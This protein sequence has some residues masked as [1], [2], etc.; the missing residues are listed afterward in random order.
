MKVVRVFG[1]ALVLLLPWSLAA[2]PIKV[3]TYDLDVEFFP[4]RHFMSASATIHFRDTSV[5]PDTLAF[6]LHGELRVDSLS[7]GKRALAAHQSSEF[8]YYDYSLIARR[9]ELDVSGCSLGEGLTVWYSGY[10]HPSRA[11]APSDY[12][13]IDGD[14]VF[15]RSYGYSVW[16]PV[17]LEQS[18]DSYAVSFSRARIR[19][20]AEFVSVFVGDRTAA[21]S[22]AGTRIT[23]WRVEDVDLADVQCT[24]RRFSVESE[25]DFHVYYLAE[26]ESRDRAR[27]I[28]EFTR[29]LTGF[30]RAHYRETAV[31]GELHIMQM[32]QY[33]DISC[34]NVA[35]IS[36]DA[37]MSF[38]QETYPQITLA[39]ELVHPF[40]QA[41]VEMADPIYA[42]VTE[43]FP[44][45]FH[46]LALRESLGEEFFG[47]FLQ[48]REAGY[49]RGRETG[50]DRRSRLLPAERPIYEITPAEIGT[51]KDC[52]VLSDRAP[53]FLDYLRRRMGEEK[54]FEFAEELVRFDSLDRA[55]FE[56]T[57]EKYLPG[58][59]G[60][61]RLWLETTEFPERFRSS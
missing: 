33:G 47:E 12:M 53:L 23:E 42:L 43:G 31:P 45:Y 60:D 2:D 27:R 54:F 41:P 15:L 9:V 11:R 29:R 34:D 6:F 20:P 21:S 13:R 30:Y 24:A 50:R 7:V 51:Y 18:R 28:L 17:F 38:E 56:N 5:P 37:W 52:F 39:H 14:G 59:G 1:I 61:V 44:G 4:D 22:E 3:K 36:A 46:L 19:T 48:S 35:G 26:P 40:V 10:F 25:G 16:F 8:Y 32:P 58:S 57:V 55:A 49:V